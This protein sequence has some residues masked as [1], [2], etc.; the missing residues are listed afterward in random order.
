M[1]RRGQQ[2]RVPPGLGPLGSVSCADSTDCVA[3]FFGDDGSSSEILASTDGGQ[4]WSE[5]EC[6][7]LAG[8]DG[9]RSLL[10]DRFG[11]LGGRT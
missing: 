7:R 11:V 6:V 2:R 8:G 9:D 4:S 5:A 10:P 3:S 1:E